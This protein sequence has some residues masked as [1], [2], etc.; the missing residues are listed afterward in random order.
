L[1]WL[2]PVV[3]AGCA[4]GAQWAA[5]LRLIA[6]NVTR[7]DL[8]LLWPLPLALMALWLAALALAWRRRNVF[9]ASLAGGLTALLVLS[10][11][12]AR[13]VLPPPGDVSELARAQTVRPNRRVPVALQGWVAAQPQRNDN[14]V[15]FPFECARATTV[16]GAEYSGPP[17]GAHGGRVWV[18]APLDADFSVGDAL[19]LRAELETL[20]EAGNTA[21]R[22]H[23]SRYLLHGCWCIGRLK[24]AHEIRLVRRADRYPLAQ[25]IVGTRRRVLRHYETAFAGAQRVYPAST[26]QLLTAMVF[27]EG[28]LREPLPRQ[29]RDAFRA[30]GLSHLLVASGTQV[31]LL[32]ALLLGGA[33]LLGLRRWWLVAL[34]VPVLVFYALVAGGAA[35]IWRATI[36]GG[37]LAA[38]FVLGRE[39]DGLTLWSLALIALLAIDPAG[40]FDLSLQLSFAATWGLLALSPLLRGVLQRRFGRNALTDLAALTLGAQMATLPILLYQFGRVSASSVG[41]NFL[42]VPLAGVLVATGLAGLVTPHADALNYALTKGLADVATF[43]AS[44]PGA[45][46]ETP[47]LP[48]QWALLSYGGLLLLAA[49]PVGGAARRRE[50]LDALRAETARWWQR[51]RERAEQ[52]GDWL[53]R[54]AT[55][56]VLAWLFLTVRA[57]SRTVQQARPAPLLVAVL[58]VGQGEAIVIHSPA[59]R[60]VLIDGGTVAAPDRGDVGRSVIVPYLAALGVRKIDALVITHADADHVNGL[61]F[62]LHEIPI[63]LVIDGAARGAQSTPSGGRNADEAD[64]LALRAQLEARRI[65]IYAARP[66]QRLN[67]GGGVALRVLA[68]VEPLLEGANNNAAVLRLEYGRVSALFTG[69]IER[70]A[71]ERLVRRGLIAPCTILKVAHHGSH[72]STSPLFLQ[73]ARPQAAVISCGRYNDFGHPAPQTVQRLAAARIPTFRTDRQGAVEFLC[74]R[75]ACWAQTYR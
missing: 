58:D 75:D 4:L 2:A 63:G 68:P 23:R 55:W 72:T 36:G 14:G 61:P 65:P 33:H 38:A 69:D 25:L 16:A 5:W 10:T 30:A 24:D 34:A 52:R 22:E 62:V 31:A 19:A 54:P 67:L 57:G 26:A 46:F 73:A 47:P 27:G 20:P 39:T 64:Y 18:R 35:S 13:R 15:E 53:W 9:T 8:L 1:V 7:D 71:E 6:P 11:L 42:G 44:L 43:A 3:V 45:Q 66:G 32:A 51:R 28:G 49:L 59:G 74:N 17:L 21:E 12:T 60:T 41:A 48:A 50:N 40:L 56:F 37:L 29:T 70:P